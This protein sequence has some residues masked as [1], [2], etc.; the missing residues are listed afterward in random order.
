MKYTVLSNYT[1]TIKERD[2]LHVSVYGTSF[3]SA[4]TLLQNLY[5]PSFGGLALAFPTQLEMEQSRLFVCYDF[6]DPRKSNT[7]WL[8]SAG[9]SIKG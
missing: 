6:N 7:I 3:S 4:S 2:I 9:F 1:S 5:D 8:N